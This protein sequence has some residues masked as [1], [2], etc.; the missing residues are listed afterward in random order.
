MGAMSRNKGAKGER[1]FVSLAKARGFDAKRS[2]FQIGGD[3]EDV[4]GIEGYAVEVKRTERLELWGALAQ[5][6]E[7]ADKA[8]TTPLLAF[9]RN[10]SEWHV[11]MPLDSFF[12]L[13]EKAK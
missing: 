9:R 7:A 4:T 5:A 2:F 6:K 11:A 3:R 10:R 1:E 8:N 13:L 12:D